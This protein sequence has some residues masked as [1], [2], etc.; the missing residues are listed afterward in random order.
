[1]LLL[2]F[3]TACSADAGGRP[4]GTKP[5]EHAKASAPTAVRVPAADT[6]FDYQIGGPYTPPDGVKAVSRDRTAKPAPG[7]YNVCY[8]NAFQTQPDSAITWWKDHHPELLLRDG[9]GRPVVDEDWDEPLLDISSAGKRAALMEVVGPWIDGCAD[10]GY[11]AVEAD[12]LD[13]YQRSEELLTAK[14]AEAFAT[15]LAERAHRRHLAFGQKNT[16]ELLSRR[17]RIGFDFAVVEE[18]ARYKEC[19]EFSDAYH[20]KVF[21]IE[22][23][24]AD[25]T[26]GCDTWGDSLSINL[27]DLDVRPAGTDGHVSRRCPVT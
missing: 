11:D 27:R 14:D 12:N 4:D 26:K 15:L 2:A 1:M 6:A 20:G 7:L 5:S 3:T 21:D 19:P 9:E 18:C 22:Y 24:K 17:S 16:G 13:S 8:V 25:F 23:R 10:A